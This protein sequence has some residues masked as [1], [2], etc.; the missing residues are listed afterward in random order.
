MVEHLPHHPE[1]KG[2]SQA[3]TVDTMGRKKSNGKNCLLKYYISPGSAKANGGE[4]KS[5]LGRVFNFKLD[6]F[7]MYAIEQHIQ[8][9]PSLEL[10]TWFMLA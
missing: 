5:C 2:S 10:K 9:H 1:V 7:V 6:W 3:A 8:A 4:S